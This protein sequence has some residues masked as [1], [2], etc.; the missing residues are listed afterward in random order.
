M[1][2]KLQQTGSSKQKLYA[3]SPSAIHRIYSQEEAYNHLTKQRTKRE[4]ELYLVV[5]EILYNV[6][7]ALCVSIDDSCREEYLYFLPHVFDLLMKTTDGL[8]IFDYLVFIEETH[9]DMPK[10]DLLVR[11]RVNRVVKIL[12]QYRDQ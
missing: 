8:D 2:R 9:F 4:Q 1:T 6:W 3:P 7:D 12:L 11:Y 5:D 10:N